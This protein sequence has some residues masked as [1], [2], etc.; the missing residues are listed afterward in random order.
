M[1]VFIQVL[2][3]IQRT[4]N[5]N[6]VCQQGNDPKILLSF[7]HYPSLQSSCQ[8]EEKGFSVQNSLWPNRIYLELPFS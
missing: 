7:I 5:S 6:L 2:L 8:K 1:I 4:A 3:Q